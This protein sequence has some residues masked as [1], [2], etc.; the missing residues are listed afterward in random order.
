VE[1]ARRRRARWPGPEAFAESLGRKPAFAACRADSL[2]AQCRAT[3]RPMRPGEDGGSGEGEYTLC[4]PPEVESALYASLIDATTFAGLTGV[5][6][7]VTLVATDPATAHED[8]WVPRAMSDLAARIPDCRIEILPEVSHM[9]PLEN[10]EACA[11]FV[12]DMIE[13]G[14]KTET[15]STC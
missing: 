12:L 9:M 3:L 5:R 7:P 4:C 13:S 11:G 1:K 14:V 15:R 2:A 10:P 6:V 8:D